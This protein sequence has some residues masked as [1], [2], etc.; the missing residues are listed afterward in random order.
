LQHNFIVMANYIKPTPTLTGK[1]AIVFLKQLEE[2]QKK[3]FPKE[4]LE[5]MKRN[6]R[7]FMSKIKSK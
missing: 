3:P 7:L 6:V 1:D 4:R 2:N 5:E